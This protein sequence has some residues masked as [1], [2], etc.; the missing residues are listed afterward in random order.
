M[1]GIFFYLVWILSNIANTRVWHFLENGILFSLTR[2]QKASMRALPASLRRTPTVSLP[3]AA[4][5]QSE[6]SRRHAPPSPLQSPLL[7]RHA[8]LRCL[9]KVPVVPFFGSATPIL[10]PLALRTKASLRIYR[11]RCSYCSR[12]SH[13]SGRYP[14]HRRRSTLSGEGTPEQPWAAGRARHHL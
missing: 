13:C 9:V 10:R 8:C 2:V 11:Y 1:Q 7:L 14:P 6:P 12:S 3:P 5:A 4:P